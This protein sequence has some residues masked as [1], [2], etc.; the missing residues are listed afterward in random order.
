MQARYLGPYRVAE[1]TLHGLYVLTNRAG[2]PLKK[3]YPLDQLKIIDPLFAA[4]VWEAELSQIFE[5]SSILDHRVGSGRRGT[6]YLVAWAGFD[7]DH[8]SW[9]KATDILD[10]NLIAQYEGV[11]RATVDEP[12]SAD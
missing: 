11:G 1:V 9:V 8:N 7:S 10:L 2:L 6:E 5:V 3:A 12:G 4:A